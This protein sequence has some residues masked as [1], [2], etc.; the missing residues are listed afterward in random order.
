MVGPYGFKVVTDEILI[1][2][3]G[4][5]GLVL[6]LFFVGMEI[7]LPSLITNWKVSIIG[8]SIQIVV[9]VIIVWLLGKFFNWKINEVVMLGFVISLS[10]TA[11]IVKMLQERNASGHPDGLHNPR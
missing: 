7:H 5:L 11:V 9:S 2:N 4:S 3:I 10:S 1:T 8:T 6:L